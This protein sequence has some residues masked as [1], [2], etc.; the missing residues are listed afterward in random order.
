MNRVERGA[1]LMGYFINSR[2]FQRKLD[3]E[4]KRKMQS[5][6]LLDELWDFFSLSQL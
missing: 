1:L 6:F 4:I 3:K 2:Q 5:V